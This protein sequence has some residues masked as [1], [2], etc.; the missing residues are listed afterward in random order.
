MSR[1]PRFLF[2]VLLGLAVVHAQ[3]SGSGDSGLEAAKVDGATVA[4]KGKVK[5]GKGSNG[6]SDDSS[7]QDFAAKTK[8][9]KLKDSKKEK[10]KKKSGLSALLRDTPVESAA[11]T[12]GIVAMVVGAVAATVGYRRRHGSL[13]Q[14]DAFDIVDGID[15]DVCERTPLVDPEFLLDSQ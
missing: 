7:T 1:V 12:V 9:P 5:D 14:Q 11:V 8:D 3:D 10:G 4:K 15:E 2:L 13:G 6:K